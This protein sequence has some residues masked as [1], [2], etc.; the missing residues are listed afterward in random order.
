MVLDEYMRDD[1]HEIRDILERGRKGEKVDRHALAKKLL[2]LEH[3]VE[4]FNSVKPFG[5]VHHPKAW[6][7]AKSS[8]KLENVFAT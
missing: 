6:N 8:V 4:K 5:M 3:F 1:S 2:I 7:E